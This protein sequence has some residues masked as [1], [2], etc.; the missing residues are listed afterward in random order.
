MGVVGYISAVES[1]SVFRAD[2]GSGSS[3]PEISGLRDY[4]AHTTRCV[5]EKNGIR[6][7]FSG[8]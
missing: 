4:D 1:M 6:F 7:R 8:D 3:K 2:G 5:Q